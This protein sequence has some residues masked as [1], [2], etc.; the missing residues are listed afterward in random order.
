MRFLEKEELSHFKFQKDFLKPF[1]YTMIHNQNPEIRDLVRPFFCF[2]SYVCIYFPPKGFAM[3]ATDDTSTRTKYAFWLAYHVRCFFCCFKGFNW[4][5]CIYLIII[6]M[7]IP[8]T[9]R[10]SSQ[11]GIWDRHQTKPWPLPCNHSIW[12][13]FWPDNLH[14]GVLQSQ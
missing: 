4:S 6:I 11:F 2:S 1:E 5:V 7:L 12:G 8:S 13:I 3:L 14:H 10:T 9:S